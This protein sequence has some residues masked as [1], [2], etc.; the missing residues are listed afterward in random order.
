MFASC[1]CVSTPRSARLCGL[2]KQ[3]GS[4]PSGCFYGRNVWADGHVSCMVYARGCPR[5]QG[6]QRRLGLLYQSAT[7][8]CW[9]EV[10]SFS[11]RPAHSKGCL[12]GTAGCVLTFC[13]VDVSN[14]PASKKKKKLL[15]CWP[16]S[17]QNRDVS[18]RRQRTEDGIPICSQFHLV[19]LLDHLATAQ[20]MLQC[21][22]SRCSVY[23]T[24]LLCVRR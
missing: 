1:A 23:V 11:E 18:R 24:L 3:R 14:T 7:A 20:R 12:C 16:Y 4:D 17:M 10:D 22:A 21:R 13:D 5:D 6:T 15:I 8:S 19:N 9:R 2:W